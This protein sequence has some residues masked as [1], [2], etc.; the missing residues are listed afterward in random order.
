[1][2]LL[3]RSGCS[4]LLPSW[5]SFSPSKGRGNYHHHTFFEG[6]G[7][8]SDCYWIS[9]RDAENKQGAK[10]KFME[11]IHSKAK[12]N[13][14]TPCKGIS[15]PNYIQLPQTLFF[16][17]L[18][19]KVTDQGIS[20]TGCICL[21]LQLYSSL[22]NKAGPKPLCSSQHIQLTR[23]GNSLSTKDISFPFG[24]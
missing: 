15:F 20:P 22:P 18:P 16:P 1:M 13:G 14:G 8:G 12:R 11:K 17:V 5:I 19:P 10:K 6:D 24:R 7:W 4:S 9:R 3:E 23:N 21:A 2:A